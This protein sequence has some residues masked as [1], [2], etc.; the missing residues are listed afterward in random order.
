MKTDTEEV[1]LAAF[2]ADPVG[3]SIV[4]SY[5]LDNPA[6]HALGVVDANRISRT[7]KRSGRNGQ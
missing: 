5:L 6:I 1:S 7:G 4:A 2:T 3:K